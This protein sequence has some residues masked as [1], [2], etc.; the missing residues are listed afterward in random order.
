MPP[1]GATLDHGPP[2]PPGISGGAPDEKAKKAGLNDLAGKQQKPGPGADVGAKQA[3]AEK[4]MLVEK[5]LQDVAKILPES[6]SIVGDLTN[7]IRQ[8]IGGIL[9][10]PQDGGGAPAAGQGTNLLSSLVQSAAAPS[11]T[12]SS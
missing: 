8:K 2:P 11:M 6:A 7:Q 4:M 5:T 12:P 9:F 3:V 1:L 10:S